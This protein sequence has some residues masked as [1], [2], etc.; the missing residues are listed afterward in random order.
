MGGGA[1]PLLVGGVIC[2]VYSGNGRD[3]GRWDC[4]WSR[5][6]LAH[7]TA[8]RGAK[9]REAPRNNRSVMPFDVLGC[10]R[11]TL[12]GGAGTCAERCGESGTPA[13]L[14]IEDCN[15]LS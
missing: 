13:V 11:A 10:T 8:T 9:P 7:A 6:A 15:C 3:G 5:D 1:W 2:Q 12:A 4:V 14:G